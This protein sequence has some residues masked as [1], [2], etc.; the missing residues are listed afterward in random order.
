MDKYG[1]LKYAVA[2]KIQLIK[3]GNAQRIVYALWISTGTKMN[4]SVKIQA[5]N[6]KSARVMPLGTRV[7]AF[8]CWS[9]NSAQLCNAKQVMLGIRIL[10]TARQQK[11]AYELFVMMAKY[12]TRLPANANRGQ[13]ADPNLVFNRWFGTK[14][15]VNAFQERSKHSAAKFAVPASVSCL[16]CAPV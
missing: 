11:I 13:F 10:V 3:S 16:F 2:K 5:V 1:A 4:V 8:V 6:N 12:S 14:S 7:V 9:R 15:S